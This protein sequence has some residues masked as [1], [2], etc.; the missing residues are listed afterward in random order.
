MKV[1]MFDSH[2]EGYF[3]SFVLWHAIQ[4]IAKSELSISELPFQKGPEFSSDSFRDSLLY[5]ASS[6]RQVEMPGTSL[7]ELFHCLRKLFNSLLI[8]AELEDGSTNSCR[9]CNC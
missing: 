3:Q 1:S 9:S 2:L 4:L 8:K 5:S 7:W 6:L